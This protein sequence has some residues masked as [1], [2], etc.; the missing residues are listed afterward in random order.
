MYT[1]LFLQF[2]SFLFYIF[3]LKIR[4]RFTSVHGHFTFC[5]LKV[6]DSQLLIAPMLLCKQSLTLNWRCEGIYWDLRAH[7]GTYWCYRQPVYHMT[8]RGIPQY[9]WG[10]QRCLTTVPASVR[11]LFCNQLHRSR[12]YSHTSLVLSALASIWGGTEGAVGLGICVLVRTVAQVMSGKSS[13]CI[14][15]FRE[16]DAWN[17]CMA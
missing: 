16:G 2:C 8:E 11:V 5:S 15:M 7:L 9:R 4:L 10:N 12:W 6:C 14:S 3:V 17:S 13:N 1:L